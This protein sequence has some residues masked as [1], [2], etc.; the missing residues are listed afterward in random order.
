[1]KKI[2]SITCFL[3]V[4]TNANALDSLLS[5]SDLPDM[6]DKKGSAEFVDKYVGNEITINGDVFLISDSEDGVMWVITK[7]DDTSM[8]SCPVPKNTPE[9]YSGFKIGDP[10]NVSGVIHGGDS[11]ANHD[12]ILSVYLEEGCTV[13][14]R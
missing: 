13:T 8:A 7:L 5:N 11:W 2:V 1:V 9:S 4:F 10:I 12:N 6:L 3:L 14:K